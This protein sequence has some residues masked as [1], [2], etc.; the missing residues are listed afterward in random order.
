[1]GKQMFT[2]K[3]EVVGRPSVVSDAFIKSVGQKK[4]VKESASQF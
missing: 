4:S 2:M 3:S 1:M